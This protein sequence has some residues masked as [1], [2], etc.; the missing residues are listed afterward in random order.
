MFER[1]L[2][3]LDG[4]ELAEAALPYATSVARIM[5]AEL[6]V[7][8]VGGEQER[9]FER[10]FRAYLERIVDVLKSEALGAKAVFLYGNPPAEIIDYAR[11]NNIG[12]IVMATHGRSGIARWM[13]G[14]VAE[15]VIR[16]SGTPI[17]LINARLRKSRPAGEI[18][19]KRILVTLDGSAL[20]SA[21]LALAEELALKTGAEIKLL[22]IPLPPYRITTAGEV[23]FSFP[24]E[25]LE[26]MKRAATGYLS[27]VSGEVKSKGIKVTAEI[28]EGV[29]GDVIPEYAKE[30]KVDLLALATHGRGGLSRLVFG[31]VMDRM[32][33]S[34]DIPMLVARGKE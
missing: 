7:A 4:S 6:D 23:D 24:S 17:L 10:L 29:A 30:N 33:H 19:F 3:T 21:A 20:G 12:L 25:L 32:L 5:G 27:K 14:S 34:L 16:G 22:H 28:V 9:T 15:K 31:S 13:M 18:E 1:V 26:D 2:V 11:K 8:S